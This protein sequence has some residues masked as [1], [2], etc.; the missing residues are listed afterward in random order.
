MVKKHMRWSDGSGSL[1]DPNEHTD[2]GFV[3]PAVKR[4]TD[5]MSAMLKNKGALKSLL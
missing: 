4:P 1:S 3:R 5:A 2:D